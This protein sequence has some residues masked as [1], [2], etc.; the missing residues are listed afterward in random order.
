M[1]CD[2]WHWKCK[3][4]QSN[5]TI[6]KVVGSVEPP[7]NGDADIKELLIEMEAEIN[8]KYG[9]EI[10]RCAKCGEFYERFYLRLNFSEG[11]YEVAYKKMFNSLPDIESLKIKGIVFGMSHKHCRLIVS[12]SQTFLNGKGLRPHLR[13]PL[14]DVSLEWVGHLGGE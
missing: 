4:S 5:N 10:Y 2:G 3:I 11:S 13:G 7:P 8:D 9:H 1:V 14:T 6:K 12:T